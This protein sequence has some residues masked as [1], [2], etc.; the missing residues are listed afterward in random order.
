[1][2]SSGAPQS[3][4]YRQIYDHWVREEV[5]IE[6]ATWTAC[7]THQRIGVLKG[8]RMSKYRE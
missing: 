1:M 8:R 6:S 7:I 5:K 3:H 2:D 4:A